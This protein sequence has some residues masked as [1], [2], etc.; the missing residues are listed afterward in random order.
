MLSISSK[1]PMSLQ[2]TVI[3]KSKILQTNTFGIDTMSTKI[4]LYQN[5][6]FSVDILVL[7]VI[8]NR[9]L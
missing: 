5:F 4:Y 2:L 7:T 6:L 3:G 9:T 8:Y 1:K